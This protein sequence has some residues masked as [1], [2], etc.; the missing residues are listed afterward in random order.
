VQVTWAAQTERLVGAVAGSCASAQ[1]HLAYPATSSL[2]AN[3]RD[4][5][6]GMNLPMADRG[7]QFVA[8]EQQDLSLLEIV[9]RGRRF[10]TA[11]G[12]VDL[13]TPPI[14]RRRAQTALK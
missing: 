10:S 13:A 5:G 3:Q 12:G 14:L 11:A 9:A 7:T 8:A 6:Q 2:H 4:L 1:I